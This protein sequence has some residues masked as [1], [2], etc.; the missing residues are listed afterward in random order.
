VVTRGDGGGAGGI[1]YELEF[2]TVG[3]IRC[4]RL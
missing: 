1:K 4:R 3:G 2:E